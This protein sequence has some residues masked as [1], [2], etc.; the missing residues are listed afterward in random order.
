MKCRKGLHEMTE[1]NTKLDRHGRKHCRACTR[2]RKSGYH[3]GSLGVGRRSDGT[4]NVYERA[5][6]EAL[7]ADPPVI[8]WRKDKGG[9]RRAVEVRDPHAETKAQREW[10]DRMARERAALE[11]MEEEA[12]EVAERFRQYRAN[13]TP[14]MRAARTEL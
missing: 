8:V 2:E 10:D 1:D 5:M 9:V 14:L 11:A 3:A 13:N 7:E 12:R 4:A 6:A